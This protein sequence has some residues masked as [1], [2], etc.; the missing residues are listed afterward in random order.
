MQPLSALLISL[1]LIAIS[2]ASPILASGFECLVTYYM[3]EILRLIFTSP[4]VR[5]EDRG[6]LA[7]VLA[8][9]ISNR[10]MPVLFR[11]VMCS[12]DYVGWE[13]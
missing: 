3:P 4:W 10:L 8:I 5:K 11:Q 6:D 1:S 7:L 12:E 13:C 9:M 2:H